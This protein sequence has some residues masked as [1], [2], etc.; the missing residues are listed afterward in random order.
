[1]CNRD[2]KVFVYEL[3]YCGITKNAHLGLFRTID[4]C[5]DVIQ[6]LIPESKMEQWKVDC[7]NGITYVSVPNPNTEDE[8]EYIGFEIYE[9]VG[10]YTHDLL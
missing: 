9:I 5:Y 6:E 7:L 2:N 3:V 4:R 8:N 1:M 10:C